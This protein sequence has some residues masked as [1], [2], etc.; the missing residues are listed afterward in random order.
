[1]CRLL[2]FVGCSALRPSSNSKMAGSRPYRPKIIGSPG[3]IGGLVSVTPIR[4]RSGEGAEAFSVSYHS[5]RGDLAWL[6]PRLG[7]QDAA[8]AAAL[9]LSS[10]TGAVVRR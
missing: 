4:D 7:S 6:S 5:P 3:Q 2:P 8:E 1:V 9:V 10:F